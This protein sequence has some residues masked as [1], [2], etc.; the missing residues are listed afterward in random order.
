MKSFKIKLTIFI[1]FMLYL[2]EFMRINYI[3]YYTRN[4]NEVHHTKFYIVI[5]LLITYEIWLK[6]KFKLNKAR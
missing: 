4:L 2:Y 3:S 5:T 1:L 6:P